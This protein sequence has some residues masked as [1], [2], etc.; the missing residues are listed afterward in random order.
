MLIIARWYNIRTTY[1]TM[2]AW[3]MNMNATFP[4]THPKETEKE[5]KENQP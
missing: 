5:E 1:G 2:S 4:I 3:G